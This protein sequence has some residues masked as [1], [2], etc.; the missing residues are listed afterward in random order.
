[1]Y[2]AP[3]HIVDTIARECTAGD[4]VHVVLIVERTTV[5]DDSDRL[6]LPVTIELLADELL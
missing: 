5:L 4:T 3:K 6:K 2:R 1:M